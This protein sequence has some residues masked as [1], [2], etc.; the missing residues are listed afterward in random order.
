MPN[1]LVVILGPTSSGKTA[2]AT[3]L[4]KK[5]NG[6]IV[7]ADSR[8]I[9]KFMDIGTGKVPLGQVLDAPVWLYDV[10]EPGE[11]FSAADFKKLAEE[12]IID[13]DRRH[14]IPFVVGGTGFYIEAL[15]GSKNLA[16][17]PANIELRKELE[18]LSTEELVKKLRSLDPKRFDVVDK[19]NRR[20]L[21]RS[22]EVSSFRAM[23][24]ATTTGSESKAINEPVLCLGLM[25]SHDF[26]YSRVDA[27]VDAI[28]KKGLIEE[29]QDLVARGYKDT[30]QLQG[31]IYKS[32]VAHLDNQ[33]SLEEMSQ[34]IKYDLHSYIR[35][36]ETYFRKM[37]N[38]TWLDI[39]QPTFDEELASRVELYL[40]G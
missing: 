40:N 35:R 20:R 7:S 17:V 14:K 15:L 23:N 21:I 10:V 18:L 27:W 33:I 31:L 36:Q 19:N 30:P 1:K 24:V 22:V 26:L 4:C 9:Y 5:F 13:I 39:T 3:R 8:Q 6:E 25:G 12:R 38:V 16:Q 32:V 29:T 28:V 37:P 34:R 2:A 11:Y